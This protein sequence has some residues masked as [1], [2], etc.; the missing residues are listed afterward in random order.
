[1]TELRNF[2]GRRFQVW[3]YSVG[4]KQLLLR[5]TKD[6]DHPTRVEIAFKDVRAMQIPTVIDELSIAVANAASGAEARARSG[7]DSATGTVFELSPS[8]VR[9]VRLRHRWVLGRLAIHLPNG[10]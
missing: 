7:G 8:K 3:E 9:V 10:T 5:S 1:M 2:P 4:H 6:V